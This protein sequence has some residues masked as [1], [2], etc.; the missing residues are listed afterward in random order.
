MSATLQTKRR[1]GLSLLGLFEAACG[2]GLLATLAGFFAR[3]WWPLELTTHFRP[4]LAVAL[5]VLTAS[6]AWRRRRCWVVACGI[7]CLLNALVILPRFFTGPE[8]PTSGGRV[9]K[10]VSLNVHTSN[11]RSELVLKF[12]DEANADIVLL[13]EVDEA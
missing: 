11:P 12:L 2:M 5:L 6:W 10:V 3:L 4:H 9:L 1:S 13:M 7:G 8:A